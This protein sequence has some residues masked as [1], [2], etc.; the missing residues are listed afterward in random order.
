MA[1]NDDVRSRLAAVEDRL[2]IIELEAAYAR[3]FDSRSGE[4]WAALFTPDGIYQARGATAERGNYVEGRDALA[5]FC[6]EAP[7]DGIH[8]MHLP[9]CTFDGDEARSRI[10]LEFVAAFHGDGNPTVRM[11]GYYDVRYVKV[12]EVWRIAHRVTTTMHR[13]D[14]NAGRYPPGTA[15]DPQH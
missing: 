12:D 6:S 9:Q 7:F 3:A 1:D 13:T 2:A 14:T 8:L 4:E 10:H 11:V 5:A 15:F